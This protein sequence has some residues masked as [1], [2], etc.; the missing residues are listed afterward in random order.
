M[1][2]TST[3]LYKRLLIIFVGVSLACA[4]SMVFFDL[5]A[6]IAVSNQLPAEWRA[7]ADIITQFGKSAYWFAFFAI[8]AAL[9]WVI[10]KTRLMHIGLFGVAALASSG[11]VITILKHLFGRFRP[12]YWVE[13]QLYGFDP[14]AFESYMNTSF[15]SGHSQTI[16]AAMTVLYL[17]ERRAWP[18]LLC[19]ACVV[20]S[21][22]LFVLAHYPSDILMGSFLGATITLLLRDY[23]SKRWQERF[24]LSA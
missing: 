15:P 20:A 14:L 18:L 22:R 24:R 6:A 2:E 8:A 4:F 5:G 9:G 7:I 21:S 11:L 17:A 16:F 10:K 12:K 13:Q 3:I 23:A 1:P 19:I